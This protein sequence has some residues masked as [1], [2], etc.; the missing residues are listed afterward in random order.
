[1]VLL[2]LA[3]VPSRSGSST[4]LVTDLAIAAVVVVL[5]L[6][7]WLVTRWRFDGTTLQ[8]E[9]G[10]IRRDVRRVPVTRIQAV[11]IFQ[12][13]LARFLGV[14]EL[15]I[16]VAGAAKD[17][18]LAC[19]SRDRAVRLRAALL[20]AHHGQDP[21]TTPEPEEVV[22]MVVPTGRL[23]GSVLLSGP[24]IVLLLLLVALGVVSAYFPA[25]TTGV[26]GGAA[27]YLFAVGTAVWR[28]FSVLYGFTVA[29]SPDGVRIR[30]GLLGTV[31]ETIP[32]RRV[33]A[34]RQVEPLLWRALGWCRLEVDLAGVPG[35]DRGSGS[36]QARKALL[37]VGTLLLSQS[38]REQVIGAVGFAPSPPPNRARL[39]APLSYH[40]LAAGHDDTFALA[41]TGRLRRVSCWVPLD[42]AQSVRWVQGPVQRR[43]GLATV[44]VDVA[45]RRVQAAFR[46]RDAAD[47]ERLVDELTALSRVARHRGRPG[48]RRTS[49][50]DSCVRSDP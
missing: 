19:L 8:Y 11:D 25:A 6:V 41:V 15:R 1:M 43:L 40:F 26:A 22:A 47:S 24:A 46:N 14:A 48:P 23:I 9:T 3:L 18:R 20:A 45:G 44:H 27:F 7:N 36:S 50:A 34:M 49:G 4:G 16:H 17:T 13:L 5:G 37:P 33:Q 38:L 28:R 39:K 29:Y 10:L 42:K 35:R 12:P 31:A 32:L 2:L 21:A 30:R